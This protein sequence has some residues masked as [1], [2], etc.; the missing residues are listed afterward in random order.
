[1]KVAADAGTTDI[2]ATPHANYRYRYQPEVVKQRIA[3]LSATVDGKPRIYQGCDFHLSFEN[4][5]GALEDSG[6][7]VINGSQY[8]LVEFPD[9]S[10]AGMRRILSALLDRGL[11]PIMT[12]PERNAYL[13]QDYA[14][15][16]VSGSKRVVWFR[17]TGQS[18]LGR[19]GKIAEE[20]SWEMLRR[21]LVH[22]VASDATIPG[23]VHRG[24][25]PLSKLYPSELGSVRP[26]G[27]FS[28]PPRCAN[29]RHR[30]NGNSK[31]K[32][33]VSLVELTA[34]F[35]SRSHFEGS[36]LPL[37]IDLNYPSTRTVAFPF[38]PPLAVFQYF[39]VHKVSFQ[40]G[41]S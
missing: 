38:R 20:A 40:Q 7:F 1:M 4:V 3:E 22:F 16:P 18:L 32:I 26:S 5:Q 2:V 33:L 17:L 31:A 6:R 9:T 28:T 41:E 35:T 23:I 25:M 13:A 34:E 10:M 12:H 29:G 11:V 37:A 24:W 21:G 30:R 39:V 8:L 14:G 27:S 19:F 15:I 36:L